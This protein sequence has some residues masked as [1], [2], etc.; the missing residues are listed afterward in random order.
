ML[1]FMNSF[2]NLLLRST[3]LTFLFT[4]TIGFA[5]T[6]GHAASDDEKSAVAKMTM[7]ELLDE[8]HTPDEILTRPPPQRRIDVLN[9]LRKLG[10]PLIT[11][12]KTDLGNASPKVKIEATQ[13]L[14]NLGQAA[15]PAVPELV[16][17]MEDRDDNVRLW[18][19]IALGPLKDPRAFQPLVLASRDPSPRVRSAV[20]QHAAQSLADASF[21]TA[22]VAVGDKDESVRRTAIYQLKML[23]DKRAVPLMVDCLADA[24]V[25]GY[26]VRDGI[27]TANR[28]CD[29]AVMAL[30]HIVNGKFMMVPQG[31]QKGNDQK[32][33]EWQEW[34]K[35]NGDQFLK[36]LSVEPDLVQPRR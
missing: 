32:V 4:V 6:W 8:F 17:A 11:K 19:V 22:A 7:N 21:A 3:L 12:L 10:A 28:N 35:A 25:H 14:A 5:V 31:N 27:K 9:A 13:V 1:A 18:A 30:E 34:W 24:E 16:L 29:E 2:R 33:M 36:E 15:R 26:D 23:K 20:L